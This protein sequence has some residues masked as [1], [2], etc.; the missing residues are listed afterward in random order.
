MLIHVSGEWEHPWPDH[1]ACRGV[2][3][4]SGMPTSKLAASRMMG[5]LVL[6]IELYSLAA[7]LAFAAPS[8]P[9]RLP[10]TLLLC[11]LV[12]LCFSLH[13]WCVVRPVQSRVA[14]RRQ[15]PP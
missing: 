2:C 12:A 14:A 15:A 9:D 7:Y 5:C 1:C 11:L 6:A 10:E 13:Y 8:M 4:G 3:A